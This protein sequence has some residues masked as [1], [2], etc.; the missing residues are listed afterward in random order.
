MLPI[1]EPLIDVL[2]SDNVRESIQEV[3]SAGG[4]PSSRYSFLEHRWTVDAAA[5]SRLELHVEG[6][7]TSSTDGDSFRFEWTTDGTTWTPVSMPALPTVEGGDVQGLLSPGLVGTVTVRV[8]DTNRTAG[9]QTL[10]TVSIDELWLRA[11][12]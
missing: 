2:A 7:R 8:V 5:G 12:P 4:N 11:V 6:S 3:I 1:I 10:D 9:T